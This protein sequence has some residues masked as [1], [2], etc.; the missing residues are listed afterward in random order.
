MK[1]KKIFNKAS[2]KNF[3]IF[4]LSII[5]YPFS[6]L[7]AQIK[8]SPN[9]I[10]ILS[11]I[12][13]IIGSY[14]LYLFKLYL[15]FIFFSLS[16][17]LD[18]VD[19]QVARISNQVNRSSF[20]FDHFTDLFKISL[21]ILVNCLIYNKLEVWLIGFVINFLFL[22][23]VILNHDLGYVLILKKKIFFKKKYYINN[24]F[25]RKNIT[26]SLII[27]LTQFNSHSFL[28]FY[29]TPLDIMYFRLFMIYLGILFAYRINQIILTLIKIKK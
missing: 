13:L 27:I 7:F 5:S 10:T 25:F 17:I 20:R 1:Y 14:Y 4:L 3:I 28:I 24:Y 23:Y 9:I 18:F 11:V 19:G 16:I 8:V 21:I 6:R 26:R 22:F 15:F 12:T 29:F 2:E